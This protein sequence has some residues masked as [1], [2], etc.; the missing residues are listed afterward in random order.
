MNLLNWAADQV[1]YYAKSYSNKTKIIYLKTKKIQKLD[2][3]LP[4]NMSL[5]IYHSTLY[6][7]YTQS[8]TYTYWQMLSSGNIH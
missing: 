7:Y 2:S 5:S 6:K 8:G 3:V 4:L 1:K